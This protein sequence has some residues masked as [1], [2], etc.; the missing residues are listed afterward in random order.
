MSPITASPV[1]PGKCS[2][3]AATRTGTRLP[4]TW[5]GSVPPIPPAST[6]SLG[7]TRT[8]GGV[9]SV[10][11]RTR[12]RASFCCEMRKSRS[13]PSWRGCERRSLPRRPRPSAARPVRRRRPASGRPE[14]APRSTSRGGTSSSATSLP[15]RSRAGTGRSK[16]V[17]A[18]G[19]SGP[20]S[21]EAKVPSF[22][23]ITARSETSP[24]PATKRQA[25][26]EVDALE[27]RRRRGR[28]RRGERRP[29]PVREPV[30]PAV[31]ARDLGCGQPE[32]GDPAD[33]LR[34]SGAGACT[35]DR[36]RRAAARE[37]LVPRQRGGVEH[38]DERLEV[39]PRDDVE[40]DGEGGLVAFRADEGRT[41]ALGQ[42]REGEGERE[43][44]D[45]DSRS[46]GAAPEGH[47]GHTRADAAVEDAPGDADER[48]EQPRR[49]D[50]CRERDEPREQQEHEPGSLALVEAGLIGGATDES[51]DRRRRERR[52]PRRRVRRNA[53]PHARASRW[54]RR[55][56]WSRAGPRTRRVPARPG[57]GCSRAAPRPPARRPVRPRAPRRRGRRANPRRCP[58]A[59]R[60]RS[61]SR[62]GA[63][64]ASGGP[65][66]T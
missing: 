29:R 40:R 4:P 16:R 38:G 25:G 42:K 7:V 35:Q 19:R 6:P 65:R 5:S 32:D 34:T 21:S 55:R 26:A 39:L 28:H 23:A 56:R 12:T 62:S 37:R 31:Q 20:R 54:R 61:R 64:G 60:R 27:R 51:R 9:A 10:A 11:C 53:H 63:A 45:G 2:T 1:V 24:A 22:A 48:P 50:R 13:T 41:V 46:S 52:E 30:P 14:S 17:T 59:Q 58:R 47:G 3:I 36:H 18:C 57:R 33:A 15:P 49:P 8:A 66:T 44:G 43:E